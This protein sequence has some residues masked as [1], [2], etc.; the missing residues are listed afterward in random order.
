MSVISKTISEKITFT[1]PSDCVVS[2]RGFITST[3]G[4]DTNYLTI[5]NS[6]IIGTKENDVYFEYNGVVLK[7]GVTISFSSEST[8]AYAHI[9]G[10]TIE[11]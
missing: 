2:V 1:A 11:G 8:R 7:Q 5:N 4:Y 10:F 3:S 9:S 6:K